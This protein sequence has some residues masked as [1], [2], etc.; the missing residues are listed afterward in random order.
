LDTLIPYD[1]LPAETL[2]RILDD[3]VS[4]DGTDYGDYDLSVAE[5][6]QQALR[7]L[8]KSETVLLFDTESETIKMVLKEA[9]SQY[10]LM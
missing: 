2:E 10:D 9:L 8:Q 4:R 3:I 7:S 6:R 5:K 1:S